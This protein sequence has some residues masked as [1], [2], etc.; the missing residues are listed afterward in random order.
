[1]PGDQATFGLLILSQ[2]I[3]SMQLPFAIVPLIHF[4]SDPA[5]MGSFR[6][7]AWVRVLAW[8]TAIVIIGLNF[9]LAGM[10]I[11]DWLNSAGPW[12]PLVWMAVAPV[13]AILAA[14]LLWVG[15]EPLITRWI[16]KFGHAPVVLPETAGAESAA[17]PV[18]KRILVPLDHTPLDRLAVS[19]AAAM[20]RLYGAEFSCCTWRKASPAASTARKP[21]P[22]KPKPASSIWSASPNPC[23]ARE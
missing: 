20:A 4:T 6:N 9:R 17:A 5:R 3:L 19:H 23:A 18:Y 7:S 21:R 15:V 11:R 1:M 12:R 14:L 16:H 22:R 13:A 2:V 8:S 10:V